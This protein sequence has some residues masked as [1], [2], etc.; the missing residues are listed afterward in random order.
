[1]TDIIFFLLLMNYFLLTILKNYFSKEKMNFL[2]V[3]T[4]LRNQMTLKN[5]NFLKVKF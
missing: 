4:F 1:V 2:M 5:L 3:K